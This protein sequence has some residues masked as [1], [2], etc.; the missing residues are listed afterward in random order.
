MKKRKSICILISMATVLL[1]CEKTSFQSQTE[2]SSDEQ[3][4]IASR[5]DV[6]EDMIVSKEIKDEIIGIIGRTRG[7]VEIKSIKRKQP[8]QDENS[9]YYE[10]VIESGKG[11]GFAIVSSDFRYREPLCFV[12]KGSLDDTLKIEPLKYFI[13]NIPDYILRKREEFDSLYK[14]SVTVATRSVPSF[15]PENSTLLTTNYEYSR[16]TLLKTVPVEWGQCPPLGSYI[17]TNLGYCSVPAVAQVMA[18]HKKPFAGYSVSDWNN[19]IAGLNDSAISDIGLQIYNGIYWLFNIAAPLPTHIISFL[20]NNN[21]SASS[22]STYS[23]SS[24]YER[25]QYGPVI[26]LGFYDD[27]ILHPD[28]GHYW[29]ADG[30]IAVEETPI[31]VYQHNETGIIYEVRGSAYYYWRVRY[32]WGWAGSSNG[33]YNG[34]VF[35]PTNSSHNYSNSIRLIKVQP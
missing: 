20:E 34:G 26:V 21:Y 35:Q 15:T 33:W 27:P 30:T 2:L 6:P 7:G 25:L 16:D 9:T 24:L 22:S 31:Y 28:T 1:A 3:V 13:Q 17:T 10:V 32:N 11:E 18:Y 8:S 19:M 5:S 23:Y 4:G 29:I 12:E 14:E